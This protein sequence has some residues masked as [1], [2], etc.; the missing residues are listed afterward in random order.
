MKKSITNPSLT[1]VTKRDRWLKIGVVGVALALAVSVTPLL[2]AQADAA[3]SETGACIQAESASG[4]FLS[5][6]GSCGDGD[7][8]PVT[9]ETPAAPFA[10]ICKSPGYK[11]IE[12]TWSA[13]PDQDQMYRVEVRSYGDEWKLAK[14]VPTAG[15]SADG[16]T[17]LALLGK[18]ANGEDVGA[19]YS[20]QLRVVYDTQGT[21]RTSTPIWFSATT[22]VT[23]PSITC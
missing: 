9:N 1:A 18:D 13:S 2:G 23:A 21:T 3:R 12:T 10:L 11:A 7:A 4:K 8:R 16:R 14:S 5:F 22:T 17:L 15:Y 20:G 19:T 6:H